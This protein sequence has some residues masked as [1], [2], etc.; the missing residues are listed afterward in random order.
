[1]L[2]LGGKEEEEEE[3]RV[4]WVVVK[5]QYR[6]GDQLICRALIC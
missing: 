3:C 1:M 4:L 5:W 6:S 2:S